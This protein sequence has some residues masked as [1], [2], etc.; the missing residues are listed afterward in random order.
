MPPRSAEAVVVWALSRSSPVPIDGCR[1]AGGLGMPGSVG[2][3]TLRSR[4]PARAP[5]RSVR[6]VQCRCEAP[7]ALPR[8][9]RGPVR[10]QGAAAGGRRGE[11][12]SGTHGW[13]GQRDTRGAFMPPPAQPMGWICAAGLRDGGMRGLRR[14]EEGELR[15]GAGRQRPLGVFWGQ[16]WDFKVR[17]ALPRHSLG[18][19]GT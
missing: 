13:G 2:A 17:C 10:L 9:S 3:P 5:P 15:Q 14:P 1:V 19:G 18:A 4:H 7:T 6:G 12:V 8:T 11:V 16:K